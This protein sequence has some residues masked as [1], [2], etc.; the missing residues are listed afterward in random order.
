MATTKPGDVVLDPFFGTG[1]TGAVAQEARPPLHRHRARGRPIA[2]ALEAHRRDQAAAARRRIASDQAQARGAARSVRLAG[3]A[4]TDRAGDELSCDKRRA[5]ARWCGPTAR[6]S[7]GQALGLDPPGRRAGA[8]RGGLQR[9]DLLARRARRRA[10]P[11]RRSCAQIVRADGG[12]LSLRRSSRPPA[13]TCR[14]PSPCRLLSASRGGLAEDGGQ[15]LASARFVAGPPI[16]ARS[17]AATSTHR[18][19]QDRQLQPEMGED[20][21][22][23]RRA[24]PSRRRPEARSPAP[25]PWRQV[26]GRGLAPASVISPR[27]PLSGRRDRK[28]RAV[29]ALGSRR[30]GRS[31]SAG[32]PFGL[33]GRLS[34]MPLAVPVQSASSGQSMQAGRAGR[35]SWR[36]DPSAPAR[37]R[38]ARRRARAAC[39]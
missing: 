35:R 22:D 36:R 30:R 29:G 13:R 15:R 20:V 27:S 24:A 8:G 7:P 28:H 33:P 4:G 12:G 18:G 1:T 26:G 34:A 38:P 17:G 31:G 10:R 37:N 2:E 6:S 5:I 39:A 19:G 32:R 3:R 16:R 9:L 21:D 23:L 25:A 14:R 11:D